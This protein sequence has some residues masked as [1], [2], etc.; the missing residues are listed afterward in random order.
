[1]GITFVPGFVD[2]DWDPASWPARPSLEQLLE[3]VHHAV[4]VGG[5]DHVGIG[6]DF[7]GG[8]SV[9]SDATEFPRITAGLLERGYPVEAI[10]KIL[11]E[12]H[13]RVLRGALGA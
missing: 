10:R 12:N 5:I 13:L 11:G 3:H 6:S 9:L 4:E 7:D 8:G 2:A 1:M